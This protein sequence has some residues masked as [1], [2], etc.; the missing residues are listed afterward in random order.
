MPSP[1][2]KSTARIATCLHLSVRSLRCGVV[3]AGRQSGGD[4]VTCPAGRQ[5][6]V[7]WRR[8]VSD[9]P[10]P[11]GAVSRAY[12]RQIDLNPSVMTVPRVSEGPRGGPG[13]QR[14]RN[15]GREPERGLARS[16]FGSHPPAHNGGGCADSRR[17][18]RGG[19][20]ARTLGRGVRCEAP[21]ATESGEAPG[22]T[23]S[24]SRTFYRCEHIG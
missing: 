17:S 23:N 15:T 24:R 6:L 9:V 13:D 18:R 7:P 10:P 19:R 22:V 20:E 14:R 5:V 11:T 8:K 12:K 21:R 16:L 1:V 2:L 3:R 4:S